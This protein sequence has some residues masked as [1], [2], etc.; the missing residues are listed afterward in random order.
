[1]SHTT[2]TLTWKMLETRW[3]KGFD[4]LKKEEQEALAL[5]W[6]QA[7][8]MNGGLDQ[9]FHNSSGD[10]APLALSALQRLN[11]QQT[12]EVLRGIMTLVFGETY[13]T[14]HEERFPFLAEIESKLGP[15][16]DRVATNFV[17]DLKEDFLPMAVQSLEKLYASD[18]W[19][20]NNWFL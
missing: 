9:F 11:C 17:Q 8:T 19:V 6:L 10:M 3:A 7:E 20:K 13:P 5:F 4:A 2:G 18:T 14:E 1:M 16:Y 15:D 12:F